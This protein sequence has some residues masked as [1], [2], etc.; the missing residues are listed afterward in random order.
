MARHCEGSTFANLNRQPYGSL[1][2][3]KDPE[4]G[5]ITKTTERRGL[6]SDPLLCRRSAQAQFTE[7]LVVAAGSVLL[8]LLGL[9]VFP[10]RRSSS[11]YSPDLGPSVGRGALDES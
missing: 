7:L 3:S 5:I 11:A 4:T 8:P 2:T 6:R 9:W 1:N 10:R